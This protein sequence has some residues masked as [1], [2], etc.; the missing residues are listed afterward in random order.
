MSFFKNRTTSV[1]VALLFSGAFFILGFFAGNAK[2]VKDEV[3]ADNGSVDIKKVVDLY[4]RSRSDKVSF[5]Q[6]WTVWNMVKSNYVEQP[7]DETKLFYGAIKGMVSGLDDPYSVYLPPQK[8]EEFAADLAGEFSGIGAEIGMKDEQLIVIAPLPSSPAEKAGLKPK[9]RIFK[10]DDKET[11]GLTVE[12]AVSKIRGPE[13]TTV[14]LTI[15][16]DGEDKIREVTLTRQKINVPTV[17]FEKKTNDI[18]YI[19][20]SHF[21]DETVTEFD[22]A[23]HKTLEMKPKGII[24]DM[25]SNPGGYLDASVDVA[26]EWV[27]EGVVVKERFYDGK[28][29]D[30]ETTGKHRLADIPT[31]VLVDAGTASGAEIVAGALQDY[32]F[33]TLV[34]EKTFGK[35]SVQNLEVLGDGSALKLTVAKWF[36]PKDRQI[37]GQGIPVDVE[38]KEMFVKNEKQK[39]DEPQFT[40]KGVE[41]AIELLNK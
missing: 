14:K 3:T 30:Y 22:D 16:S 23:V 8:A 27:K 2:S 5:E 6:F 21:N 18:A 19:R 25:R 37:S 38:M 11:Q 15:A 4:G 13:G 10:I 31:I 41:K 28:V 24:L 12:E 17:I 29:R 7:V 9:D 26:S 1:V 32:G 33:A 35:G 20:I 40:D 39:A 36:T 34:G